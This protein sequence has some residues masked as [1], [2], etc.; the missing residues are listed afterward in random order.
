MGQLDPRVE[1]TLVS[2]ALNGQDLQDGVDI[3]DG[4]HVPVGRRPE[5][6]LKGVRRPRSPCG[7]SKDG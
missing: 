1:Y 3:L 5:I 4:I 2:G 7:S 6:G